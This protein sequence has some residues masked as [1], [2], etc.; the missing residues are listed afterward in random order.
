MA[1]DAQALHVV[2]CV[3]AAFA[4]WGDVIALGGQRHTTLAP[5]L[6]AQR[7]SC[8]QLSAC[9]LQGA[10]GDAL[11]SVRPLGP[12]LSGMLSASAR[13]IAHQDATARVA[14]GLGRG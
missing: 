12:I 4:Q 1:K 10:A 5:A 7:I 14:A 9:T 8:E 2:G 6:S 3:G 13:S 11:G